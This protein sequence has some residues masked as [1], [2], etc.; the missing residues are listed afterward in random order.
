MKEIIVKHEG[1]DFFAE[2]D[3]KRVRSYSYDYY[4]PPVENFTRLAYDTAHELDYPGT[5]FGDIY[6]YTLNGEKESGM[7]FYQV[8]AMTSFRVS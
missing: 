3:G 5:W 2:V 6:H 1:C 4:L 7:R 8:S